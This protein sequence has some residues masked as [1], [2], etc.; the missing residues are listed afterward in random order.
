MRPIQY[1][2]LFLLAAGLWVYL[3]F[4]R[5]R[6]RDRFIVFVVFISAVVFVLMPSWSSALARA[7]DVD[8][9][10]DL[11]IYVALVLL[12]F[13]VLMLYTQLRMLRGQLTQLAR[14]SALRHAQTPP[15]S[16]SASDPH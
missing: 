13:V 12:S 2:L 9:G 16:A 5:S 3:R 10:V 14:E 15:A 6:S 1:L 8:R 11:V 4:L 7:V